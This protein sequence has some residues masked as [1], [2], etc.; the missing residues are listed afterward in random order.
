M[1]RQRK[2]RA[3]DGIVLLNKARGGSS[4][5]ALQ[6]VKRLYQAQKAGHTGSLDPMATGV[7]PLCLGEATKFSQYL[8]N[9]DKAYKATIRLGQHTDSGDAEGQLLAETD[10]SALTRESFASV[11]GAFRGVIEQVP[12]MYSALKVNGQPLYKLAREG[13]EIERQAREVNIHAFELLDFRSGRYPEADVTI[14]CSKGTYIRSIAIDIG[15]VLGVGGHLVMLHRSRV[16]EF[17]DSNSHTF[18]ELQALQAAEGL[19]ALDALLIPAEEAVNH[20]PLVEVTDTSGYYVRLGQA[21]LVPRAPAVGLVRIRD[22]SG[23]F[24]GIG[25][26]LEDGRVAPRRLIASPGQEP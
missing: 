3:I 4:N 18:E 26:M 2:G 24:L 13:I 17:D 5:H 22:E 21:V 8:L 14:S 1:A 16:G 11:M 12:P 7:L 15:Q 25:E 23:C 9:A 6:A 10:A 20:L 19:P